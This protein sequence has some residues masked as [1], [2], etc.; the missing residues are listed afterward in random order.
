VGA[1]DQ[2]ALGGVYKLAAVR[3]ADGTWHYRIKLSEQTV[4]ISN[5]GLLQVRRFTR[6][7]RF[8]ADLVY[9]IDT[10]VD[11]ASVMYD[12]AD[13]T[14]PMVVE[15][16]GGEDLL[17]PVFRAGNAVYTPPPLDAVRAYARTQLDHLDARTKRFL[18]PQ[19]YPVGLERSLHQRKLRL[20]ADA[21]SQVV[22]VPAPSA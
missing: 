2:P 16:D 15:G 6:N 18:N 19:E 12:I 20:I 22:G 9:D 4:K 14:R 7:G 21:R 13:P 17:V 10:G 3:A 1:D 8:S 5:P 11:D